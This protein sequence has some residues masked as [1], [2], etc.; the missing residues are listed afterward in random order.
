VIR[1]LLPT[2]VPTLNSKTP[3]AIQS[4]FSGDSNTLG[5]E[6]GANSPYDV[7]STLPHPVTITGEHVSDCIQF[8]YN[9]LQW[10][11]GDK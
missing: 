5:P 3:Q 9:G 1:T 6:I 8:N 2:S 7:Q 4:G 11:S 10:Q